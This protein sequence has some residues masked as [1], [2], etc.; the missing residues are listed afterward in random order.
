VKHQL[1]RIA[2]LAA[3]AAIGLAVLGQ[4][5]AAIS[6]PDAPGGS[7]ADLDG[8]LTSVLRDVD[9][10]WT[11][12]MDDNGYAEPT[13]R[14]VWIPDGRAVVDGC[15]GE[16]TDP[17]A[18][19]Y[20]PAD[21][22]IYLAETFAAAV[23]DGRLSRWPSGDAVDGAL[24]DMAVAYVIAHEEAHNIQAELGLFDGSVST[25][26]LE[27]HADCLAGAWAG[28]AASRG[29]VNGDDLDHAQVTAWLVGDY[30]FD[31]PGHHGT[32]R[33]RVGAFM[34]GYDDL[35]RCRAYL[36]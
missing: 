33:E 17:T 11:R 35:G 36:G 12:V 16:P 31:D 21:D 10:Y 19:F 34:A 18:A 27:L 8:F 7:E 4:P 15:T 26:A 25:H 28:D 29:V 24:G 6:L 5:A 9:R 1:R 22:T 20:C 3:T 30:A 2:L 23:R 14:Y 32:P 13:V